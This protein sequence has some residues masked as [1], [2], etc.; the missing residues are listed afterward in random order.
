MGSPKLRLA[1]DFQLNL[2]AVFVSF[3]SSTQ[4]MT[5]F[6]LPEYLYERRAGLTRVAGYVG[7]VY[8]VGRYVVEQMDEIRQKVIEDQNAREK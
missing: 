3:S 6:G 5:L 2:Q 8:L 4:G 1:E 7:G